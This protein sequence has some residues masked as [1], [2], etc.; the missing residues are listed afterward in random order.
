VVIFLSAKKNFD[1]KHP[2]KTGWRL[3]HTCPEGPSND[4]YIRG[5]ISS[6][7]EIN[8]PEYWTELVDPRSITV[9][10]TPIGS[11]QEIIVKRIGENK[12]FLQEKSGIA[13]R[14]FL[15]YFWRKKGW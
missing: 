2:T 6:K 15:P 12:I 10:L 5:K 7:T 11:H 13:H 3:R 8:L 1:I 14:S 4:V 9:S